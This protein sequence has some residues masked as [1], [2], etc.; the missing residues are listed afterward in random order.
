MAAPAPARGQPRSAPL[1]AAAQ[2]PPTAMPGTGR[3]LCPQQARL[4]SDRLGSDRR[5]WQQAAVPAV[6]GPALRSTAPDLRLPPLKGTAGFR[7]GG[8]GARGRAVQ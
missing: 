8:R 1:G 2:P 7:C 5:G 6:P 4:G 3:R